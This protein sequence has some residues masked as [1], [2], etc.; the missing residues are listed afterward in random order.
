MSFTATLTSCIAACVCETSSVLLLIKSREVKQMFIY[1][2][3]Y[4]YPVSLFN[5]LTSISHLHFLQFNFLEL[6]VQEYPDEYFK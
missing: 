6:A 2:Y 5:F 4:I 1:I 3:I